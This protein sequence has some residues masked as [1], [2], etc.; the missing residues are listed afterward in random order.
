MNSSNDQI[1]LTTYDWVGMGIVN[2]DPAL[3]IKVPACGWCHPGGGPMEYARDADGKATTIRY[4]QASEATQAAFDGDFWTLVGDPDGDGA[5]NPGKSHWGESGVVEADCL[6]CHYTGYSFGARNTQLTYRNYKWAATAGAQIGAISGKVYNFTNDAK[7]NYLT[8][9]YEENPAVTVTYATG[10]LVNGMVDGTRLIRTPTATQCKQCHSSADTKKRGR[11]MEVDTDVHLA[12]G[13]D[14]MDCHRDAAAANPH[15]IGKG[16]AR[17]GTVA[18]DLDGTMATCA[19]CHDGRTIQTAD[20]FEHVALNPSAA[21]QN[22]LHG[23][24]FHF[25]KISCETCH[26]PYKQYTAG[27]LIDMSSGTQVWYLTSGDTIK[28]PND[29]AD[30]AIEWKPQSKFYDPD[31]AGPLQEKLYPFGAKSSTWFGRL[32]VSGEIRPMLLKE[33]KAAWSAIGSPK[34]D[35]TYVKDGT[36][37]K[38]PSLS[39]DAQKVDMLLQLDKAGQDRPVFVSGEVVYGLTAA[40]DALVAMDLEGEFDHNFSVNHDVRESSEAL[41]ANGCGDCHSDGS[42]LFEAMQVVDVTRYLAESYKSKVAPYAKPVWEFQGYEWFQADALVRAAEYYLDWPNNASL[43]HN[44]IISYAE[45]GEAVCH[46]C[47]DLHGGIPD[48]A[49]PHEWFQADYAKAGAGVCITCHTEATEAFRDS[50]HYASRSVV[51]NENFFFPGGGKHGMLDRACALVGSNMLLNMLTTGYVELADAGAATGHPAQQCGGCHTNYYMTL[52]E[53]MLAQQVGADGAEQVMLSGVDCLIC[54]AED[55]DMRLRKTLEDDPLGLANPMQSPNAGFG[56]VDGKPQRVAQDRSGAALDSI[57]GKP[58]DEM[59]LR[60]HEHGRTDYKRG[61]LPEPDHD[62][63]YELG[64]SADNPCTFCHEVTDHKFNRGAMVNG[65]IFASDY[66]VNSDENNASCMNCHTDRPHT[67][68]RLNSH[69]AKL[70]CETCHIT[71]TAGA[72]TTIW[73]DGGFL[74]LAKGTDNRPVKLYTKK[75]DDNT[76]TPEELW[77]AYRQ[78][79]IYMP[80]SGLTSF[81][82]QSIPLVNQNPM[83]SGGEAIE[84]KIFPFKTI[85]NP[86]PFDGRFFGVGVESVDQ[87]GDDINDYSMFAAMRMFAAQYK[88]LG[89]MDADFDFDAFAVDST[90]GMLV[91]TWPATDPAFPSYAAMAQMA[92]FPNMLFFDKY[93]FGHNWYQDLGELA[94]PN[95]DGDTAD[96]K[97]LLWDAD[98]RPLAV[99][100]MRKAVEVGMTRLLDMMVQMGFQAPAGMTIDMM[101]GMYG[102][103]DAATNPYGFTDDQLVVMAAPPGSEMQLMLQQM[104]DA[105]LADISD[106]LIQNYPA[107]SNGVTLG[108]HGVR[109]AEALFC[110]DCHTTEAGAN[111]FDQLVEVPSYGANGMPLMQWVFYDKALIDLA[112]AGQIVEDVEQDGY[113]RTGTAFEM[114]ITFRRASQDATA[115]GIT[116]GLEGD[117]LA[118]LTPVTRLVSNWKVL[119]Y[120][121]QR[122]GELTNRTVAGGGSATTSDVGTDVTGSSECFVQAL[123]SGAAGF[124]GWLTIPLAVLGVVGLLRRR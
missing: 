91:T 58:T 34:I 30:N 100:D 88:M 61:E 25:E 113:T 75:E 36:T 10:N 90:T 76:L 97:I 3:Q 103:Y 95:G 114:G 67:S 65:D 83:L 8:G 56:T 20:A 77:E 111:V 31:G 93:T 13:L 9:V 120:T 18:D 69:V 79:P 62:I 108:G 94:D 17:L 44:P 96:S 19:E 63:H 86:L 99:K 57:K 104:K 117:Y 98:Y 28:W 46:S 51:E 112:E 24:D 116:Y 84:P 29:F 14:C 47:H 74:A 87:D 59:C 35:V 102:K 7:D 16:H 42:A 21:H 37:I 122:I 49:F 41:G 72:E 124:A 123:G 85:I 27:E 45:D 109:R 40:G 119:G 107:W 39:T 115:L 81:L 4:D 55:Y 92:A 43:A 80:F 52:M 70:A 82:A 105:G 48:A 71:Y 1:D 11:T 118:M 101:K 33:V 12:A 110:A 2:P 23:L 15:N 22:A 54:H 64:V 73:A 50:V 89:F 32:L 6:L 5:P 60:C 66:P 68:T 26:I 38:K 121:D 78:R 106:T 53:P